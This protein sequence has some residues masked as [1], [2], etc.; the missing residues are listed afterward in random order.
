VKHSVESFRKVGV[1]AV[2]LP[3]TLNFVDDAIR[4]LD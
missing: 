4:K 2:N 3:P 1:H